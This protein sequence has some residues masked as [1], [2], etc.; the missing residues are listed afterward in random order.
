MI[1]SFRSK[2]LEELFL[3]G[4]SSKIDQKLI[5]RCLRRLDALDQASLPQDMNIPGFNF[6]GLLGNPKRYSVHINAPW[7]ITFEWREKD[8]WAVDIEQY[9]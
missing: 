7:C 1:K 2:P 4:R 5:A 6:H 8:A 9:H 3:A